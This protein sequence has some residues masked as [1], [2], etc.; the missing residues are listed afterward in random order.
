M[1]PSGTVA[2]ADGVPAAMMPGWD[3]VVVFHRRASGRQG[4][5]G[6]GFRR[7]SSCWRRAGICGP[8]S[9]TQT[10]KN[11]LLNAA[12]EVDHVALHRWVQRFTPLLIDAARP[13]RHAVG[14]RWFVDETYVE[15]AGVWHYVCR[16]IDGYG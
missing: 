5:P 3:V 7:R 2:L 13:C 11:S 4:L 15:V 14:R 9:R 1:W 16:A 8:G 10:W 6:S 12:I